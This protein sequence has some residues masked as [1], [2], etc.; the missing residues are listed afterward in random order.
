[1]CGF[2]AR[3][4]ADGT[5][6]VIGAANYDDTIEMAGT[7]RGRLGYD[8]GG[9]LYYVTGG[10]AWTYDQSVRSQI[11]GSPIGGAPAGTVETSFLGRIGWTVGAGLEAPVA[12]GWTA[13]IEYLYWQYDNTGVTFPL[14]GQRFQSELSI[15]I[16][17]HTQF[18]ARNTMSIRP[19]VPASSRRG[20][21]A[22]R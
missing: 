19:A 10:L 22:P 14:G 6:P 15:G 4:K 17:L 18:Q 5:S 9:W 11:T 1:M 16:R 2:P 20:R 3:S 8:I 21:Q 7:V 12:P 13:R